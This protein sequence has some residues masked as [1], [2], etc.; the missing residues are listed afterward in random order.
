MSKLPVALQLYSVRN[1]M[2]ED[3]EATLKAVSEMGYDG[4]EFAGL[5]GKSADEMKALCEKYSLTPISAHVSYNDMLEDENLISVYAKIGC[6]FIAIPSLRKTH[7]AGGENYAECL[8]NIKKLSAKAKKYGITLLYHNHDFEFE[9]ECGEYKLDRL[10]ADLSADVLKTQLDTCWVNVGG[11]NPSEY[12]LRYTGR[13]PV[14]HIKDFVGQKTDNMYG[15]ISEKDAKE[16]A[17][18]EEFDFRPVG[19][20]VQDVKSIV[21]AAVAAG[22]EWVVVEQDRP[23][24]D[25]SELEC[26][27]MSID[28]LKQI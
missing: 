2:K 13:A 24:L 9:K 15:L 8:E 21:D 12:L 20:G 10:Y 26:A 3:V 7:L 17:K 22:A 18:T 14:V 11:E 16:E 6:R 5:H 27:K 28:T 25:N 23:S 1:A 19:Y 4:V